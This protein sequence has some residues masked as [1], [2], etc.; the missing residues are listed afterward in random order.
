MS[1][2]I[3][4]AGADW[5]ALRRRFAGEALANMLAFCGCS[6]DCREGD[7]AGEG[8]LL[9]AGT[10]ALTLPVGPVALLWDGAP[11]SGSAPDW[12][13]HVSPSAAR[14]FLTARPMAEPAPLDLDLAAR[15]DG[16]D[17]YFFTRYTHRRLCALLSRRPPEGPA[18]PAAPAGPAG[19]DGRGLA[20]A[21]GRFPAA[22]RRGSEALDPY[23]VNR[24]AVELAGEIR[25]FLRARPLTAEHRPL[26]AAA[27]TALGNALGIL[28]L[29][30]E[31]Q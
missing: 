12:P 20:L 4:A 21:I 17:P 25:R 3:D 29:K 31:L 30:E 26:L 1:G 18:A 16:H 9:T 8:L 11:L 22:V 5:P 14:F 24:Y 2:P 28:N 27:R 19:S 6:P 15:R 13:R 23:F 10:A 7:G